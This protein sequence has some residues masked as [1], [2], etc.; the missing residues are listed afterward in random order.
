MTTKTTVKEQAERAK[1]D[2]AF[3]QALA[4]LDARIAAGY[5]PA[6]VRSPAGSYHVA[7]D[8]DA[9]MFISMGRPD[10]A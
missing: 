9:A 4:G 1:R 8:R 5:N 7:H 10:L 3:K 6:A 2:A